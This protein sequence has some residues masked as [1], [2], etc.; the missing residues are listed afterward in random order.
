MRRNNSIFF[1]PM[2]GGVWSLCIDLNAKEMRYMEPF[3]YSAV[4]SCM[5][6]LSTGLQANGNWV[7]DAV[8]SLG[9]H[10]SNYILLLYSYN[11]QTKYVIIPSGMQ[12]LSISCALVCLILLA[13]AGLLGTFGLCQKQISAI[14]ITGVMYLLAGMYPGLDRN[15][16][17][18]NMSLYL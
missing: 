11:H 18:N 9:P 14:L 2:I 17:L 7:N 12:N 13:A 16:Y 6:Y 5:N 4:Q 10:L 1:V 8:S 3:E 15:G